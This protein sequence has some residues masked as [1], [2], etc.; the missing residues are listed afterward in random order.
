MKKKTIMLCGLVMLFLVAVAL[1]LYPLI[2]TWYNEQHQS[3]IQTQY[4]ELVEQLDDGQILAARKAAE[5]YNQAIQPGASVF[6]PDGQ[7]AASEAY[8]DLLNLTGNG[9]MGYVEIPRIDVHLPIYHGTT[10]ETL[11][12]GTGHLL[13]SSLPIGGESTHSVITAHTGVASQKLFSDLDKLE[14]G[15]IFYLEVL[16]ETLAYQVDAINVVLPHE[17]ELLG[18]TEGADQCTLITCTPFAVNTHRLLV[19]GSRIPYE[20]AEELVAEQIAAEEKPASTWEQQYLKGIYIGLSAA[21]G[22][23]III[24]ILWLCRRKRNEKE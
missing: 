3:Q 24:F 5:A 4:Q 6:N 1:V 17:T 7:Q 16:G 19:R 12:A 21:A 18:I 13:G 22:M 20:E 2:S 14:L 10:A 9:I 8:E 23:G 11:D 15:D